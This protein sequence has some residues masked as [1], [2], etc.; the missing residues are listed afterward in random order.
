MRFSVVVSGLTAISFV[1]AS[2]PATVRDVKAYLKAHPGTRGISFSSP[3]F[4]DWQQ[5]DKQDQLQTPEVVKNAYIVKLKPGSDLT[6]RGE[7][8]A[9]SQLHKR[10]GDID[11]S[12]RH[13][14]KDADV[15]FGLSIQVKDEK[16]NG[17]T[18]AQIP[19]VEKVWPD[20]TFHDQVQ[21]FLPSHS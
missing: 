14:F 1:T 18:I 4:I 9:H 17:T 15:F 19:N 7:E 11:Y 6:K 21:K 13:E 12:T 20:D 5:K 8:D 10:A 3:E 2:S 16:V